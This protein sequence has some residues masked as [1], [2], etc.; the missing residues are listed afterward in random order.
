MGY[1][2]LWTPYAQLFHHESASRGND[3]S[4]A[5]LKRY[6][7]ESDYLKSKWS[8]YMNDDPSYNPNLTYDREDFALGDK[9]G[10]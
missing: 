9:S 1:R 10:E 4:P 8:E 6:T 2:N 7:Q 5:N 3:L